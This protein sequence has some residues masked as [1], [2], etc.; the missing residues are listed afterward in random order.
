MDG[1][2]SLNEETIEIA[3]DYLLEASL[4]FEQHKMMKHYALTLSEMARL[5]NICANTQYQFQYQGKSL[6]S[7]ELAMA[8]LDQFEIRPQVLDARLKSYSA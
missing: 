4:L 6:R 3:E 8:I 5:Y 2:V 1:L 7:L